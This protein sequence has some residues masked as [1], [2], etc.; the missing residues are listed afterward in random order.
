L[1][2]QGCFGFV[3]PE[4]GEQ[5]SWLQGRCRLVVDSDGL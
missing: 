3:Q 4:A 1:Y 2:G 5:S